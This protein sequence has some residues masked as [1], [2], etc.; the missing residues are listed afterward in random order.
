MRRNVGGFTLI[1]LLVVVAI[2][3]VLVAILL[4]ALQNARDAARQAVCLSNVKQL[5][6][7]HRYYLEDNNGWYIYGAKGGGR[8]G[9][10][11]CLPGFYPY[12]NTAPIKGVQGNPYLCPGDK[13]PFTYGPLWPDCPV[14]SQY[15]D[16]QGR[17]FLYTSYASNGFICKWM[18]DGQ[19]VTHVRE[20]QIVEPFRTLLVCDATNYLLEQYWRVKFNHQ[21]CSQSVIAYV[22][23]HAVPYRGIL[24]D[25]WWDILSDLRLYYW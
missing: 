5:A 16:S 1:E 24:P 6:L 7:I 8:D 20:S 18:Q 21:N 17:C 25:N 19:P 15:L 4:P 23:G 3:A 11:W 9:L 22:D 12:L 14:P 2:I 10:Y 13:E